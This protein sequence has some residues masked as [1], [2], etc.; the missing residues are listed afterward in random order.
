MKKQLVLLVMFLLPIVASADDQSGTCGK[1]LTWKFEEA[2]KTLVISGTGNME[3]YS[4]YTPWSSFRESI[5]K[6]LLEEGVA[7]IGDRA[8]ISCSSLVSITLPNSVTSIGTAAF[9]RCSNLISITIPDGLT[10]IGDYAFNGCSCLI[11]ITLPNSVTYI[12]DSA[13]YVCS[14]LT[15]ITIPNSVTSIGDYAFYHCSGLTSITLPNSVTSIGEYA[16]LEC[17]SLTSITIPNS[18]TSIGKGAFGGCS[19]LASITIPDGVIS[20]GNYAFSSCSSLT[21]ITI[22]NSVTSIGDYAFWGC[23]GLSSITIPNS[24]TSIGGYAFSRCNRITALTLSENLQIIKRNTFEGC[25]SLQEVIIP[26]KVEYIYQEAFA[27]CYALECVKVLATTPPFAYDNT[28]SNYDIPLYVPTESMDTYQATNPWRKFTSFKTLTGQDVETKVCAKPTISY[29]KGKLIF[30]CATEGA[31]CQYTITDSDIQSG[32]GNEVQLAVTYNISAYAKKTG[33]QNSETTT[34][35]LCWIEQEP[36]TE[37]IIGGV[38]NV[39]AQALLIQSEGGSLTVQGADDGAPVSVY[40]ING[41]M[42]GSAI[43]Q[44]GHAQITT[45]LPAGSVSIVKVYQ[46]AVKVIVK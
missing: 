24:V 20:I 23:S 19:S 37:G 13:F 42:V 27:D 40:S 29:K 25:R 32:A 39:P 18:V 30:D 14:G 41:A 9:S 44:N 35:T 17:S 10:Y 16:F 3:D 7:S 45:N 12:G 36:K 4:D 22:P 15:S 28:F 5:A 2:T 6:I 38:A 26:A 34:A 31:T 1:N 33:Y 46:K 21:S 11:S 43:S 8:F